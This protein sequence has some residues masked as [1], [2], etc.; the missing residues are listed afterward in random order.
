MPQQSI[1]CVLRVCC[2][3]STRLGVAER[4]KLQRLLLLRQR[5]WNQ[6]QQ[7]D[8]SGGCSY[9]AQLP[10]RLTGHTG[11][12]VNWNDPWRSAASSRSVAITSTMAMVGPR[13]HSVAAYR[14]E[15]TTSNSSK[16]ATSA[17]VRSKVFGLASS[18]SAAVAAPETATAAT[19]RSRLRIS[20]GWLLQFTRECLQTC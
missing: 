2:H 16:A 3:L 14:T 19:R 10:K 7:A 5:C 9:L 4:R 20:R 13:S 17:A 8:N 18:R 11:R 15:P 6:K 1:A 12:P